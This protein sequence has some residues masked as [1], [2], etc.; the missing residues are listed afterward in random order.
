MASHIYSVVA[1]ITDDKGRFLAVA[2]KDN[3]NDLGFPG[4]K[5]EKGESP[6]DAIFR[7]LIEETGLVVSRR[8]L[9]STFIHPDEAGRLCMA[10]DVLQY[11]GVAY[12]REGAWV[13]WAEPARFLTARTTFREYN[14]AVFRHKGVISDTPP[15]EEDLFVPAP[16]PPPQAAR[17]ESTFDDALLELTGVAGYPQHHITFLYGPAAPSL[18]PAAAL[19]QPRV[20]F[21]QR[22]FT[23]LLTESVVGIKAHQQKSLVPFNLLRYMHSL[24]PRCVAAVV[25]L[26]SHRPSEDWEAVASNIIECQASHGSQ[27]QLTLTKNLATVDKPVG[28][29]VVAPKPASLEATTDLHHARP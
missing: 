16:M 9:R 12:S 5:I 6:E 23:R 24:G 28:T 2:R 1:V 3:P 29:S 14:L 10:F 7:E 21:D 11:K 18:C 26:S 27:L 13:G 8:S 20:T 22:D 4:G 17:A 19:V 25:A 15:P